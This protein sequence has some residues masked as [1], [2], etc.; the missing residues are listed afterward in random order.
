[1]LGAHARDLRCN[2]L[3]E[4][5]ARAHF[6]L[7]LGQLT[8]HQGHE[9]ALRERRPGERRVDHALFQAELGA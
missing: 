8:D 5:V 9:I 4:R 1:V 6:T 3:R 7:K 2:P